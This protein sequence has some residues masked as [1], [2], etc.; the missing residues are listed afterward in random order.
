MSWIQFCKCNRRLLTTGQIREHKDCEFCQKEHAADFHKQFDI[1]K[2][3][4]DGNNKVG[5]S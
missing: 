1:T 5:S 4:Q 2:E 3:E